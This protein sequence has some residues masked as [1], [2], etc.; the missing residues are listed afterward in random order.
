L[1]NRIMVPVDLLHAE[2]LDKALDS[3][4]DLAKHYVIPV[5]YVGVASEQPSPISHN[6]AE[7]E[8]KFTEFVKGQADKHGLDAIGKT[9]IGHDL[10]AD[11]DDILLKAVH[12][13]GADLVVMAS[14]IP[15]LTSY[16]WPTNGGKIAAHSDASVFL[17]R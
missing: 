12:E 5:T 7:Y 4:A 15:G 13:V 6:P 17:I 8:Q 10:V 9:Y 11:V 1:F 2:K 14:H 16:I 3:A